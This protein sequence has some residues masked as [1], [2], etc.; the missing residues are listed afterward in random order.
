MLKAIFYFA[1]K[2]MV[3]QNQYICFQKSPK[4]DLRLKVS[5][6]NLRTCADSTRALQDLIQYICSDGDLTDKGDGDDVTP[7]ATDSDCQVFPVSYQGYCYFLSKICCSVFVYVDVF[8]LCG[9]FMKM[10]FA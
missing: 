6:L 4:S 9:L 8:I 7:T 2:Y 5:E 10:L 1:V 3:R